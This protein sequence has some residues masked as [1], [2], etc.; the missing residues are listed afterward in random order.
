MFLRRS[1]GHSSGVLRRSGGHVC[2]ALG[3][4]RSRF[5]HLATAMSR[6]PIA[7]YISTQNAAK[8][9]PCPRAAAG[10]ATSSSRSRTPARR[11]SSRRTASCGRAARADVATTRRRP[12]AGRDRRVDC[13]V[14]ADHLCDGVDRGERNHQD[15]EADRE[16]GRRAGPERRGRVDRRP[17]CG[18]EPE[19]HERGAD[20]RRGSR[21]AG[22]RHRASRA[23]PISDANRAAGEHEPGPR[24]TA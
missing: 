23:A 4:C 8:A 3:V 22:A 6:Q 24:E 19:Q 11:E 9:T 21:A 18:V 20:A 14:C 12:G 10:A 16:P 1:D 13:S 17:T 7:R 5:R 15:A 2:G